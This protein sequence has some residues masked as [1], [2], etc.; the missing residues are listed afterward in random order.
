MSSGHECSVVSLIK[1]LLFMS[2][3]ACV[4]LKDPSLAVA[5]ESCLRN[6]MKTFCCDNFRDE[7]ILEEL[8]AAHFPRHSR[9]QIIVTPFS[10]KVYNVQGR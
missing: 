2:Q 9:P 3:G 1:C 6:F 8:M 10:D 4:T 7:K 5:V